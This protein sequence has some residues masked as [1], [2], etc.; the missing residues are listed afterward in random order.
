M[1]VCV[2]A[3]QPEGSREFYEQ[4]IEQVKESGP[5]PPEGGLIH[6]AGPHEGGWRV[7]NVF[8]SQESYEQFRNERLIPALQEVGGSPPQVTVF[9]V[10][11]HV[12]ADGA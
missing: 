10:H 2:I 9:E 8:D 12:V 3:D 11:N 5:F 1:A 4:V 7:I 6:I